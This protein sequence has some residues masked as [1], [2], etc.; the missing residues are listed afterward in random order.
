[1]Q[2][3]LT[4]GIFFSVLGAFFVLFAIQDVNANGFGPFTYLLIL[5]ATMDIGTG[6]R[7][8]FTHIKRQ[9]SQ[10]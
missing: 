9:K 7:L 3:Y 10:K 5:L 8:I 4:R 2:S 6:I 1:M